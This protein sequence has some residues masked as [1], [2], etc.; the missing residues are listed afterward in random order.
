[1]KKL[2]IGAVSVVALS[3]AFAGPASADGF[4]GSEYCTANGD[5]SWY[6]S[7]HGDCTS[8]FESNRGSVVW[9]KLL[10]DYGYLEYYGF[11]NLGQCVAALGKWNN[12]G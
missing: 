2:L 6:F 12:G 11:K 3:F 10:K 9:C 8:Y 7:S 4:N 1:M 5:F